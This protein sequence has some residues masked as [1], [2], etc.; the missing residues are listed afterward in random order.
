M[1]DDNRERS[2]HLTTEQL[3][4][5]IEGRLSSDDLKQVEVHL[6]SDC[7]SCQDELASLTRILN[8]MTRNI[9]VDAP[10]QQQ[11][12]ARKI[13]RDHYSVERETF[14]IGQWLQTLFS[15]SRPLVYAA[16]GILLVVV[17]AGLLLRPPSSAPE[18][19]SADVV[20]YQGTVE[21]QSS[22]DDEWQS[23]ESA[24]EVT[25]GD[26][27]RTGD[28]SSIVL[29]FPDESKLLMAPQTKI[30]IVEMS[31]DVESGAQVV[32]LQQ[33]IG[34]TQNFVEP[35]PSEDSRYEIQTPA[36]TVTVWGTAFTVEVEADG[37]THVAVSEGRVQVEAQGEAI[38]LDAGEGTTVKS[39][40]APSSVEPVPTDELAPNEVATLVSTAI[41]TA[42]PLNAP[43]ELPGEQ[44]GPTEPTATATLRPTETAGSSPA[45]TPT[46][47]ASRP[48]TS[49][50]TPTSTSAPSATPT[51]EVVA[52]NTPK[53]EPTSTP[54]P[55]PVPTDTPQP[56]PTNTPV[57]P[58]PTATSPPPPTPTDVPPPTPTATETPRVPPGQTKTPQPPGQTQTAAPS[59][60]HQTN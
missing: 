59:E 16:I 29:S 12:S 28:D 44:N 46:P 34:R 18:S 39:G 33:Q 2:K 60:H 36:V 31:S 24:E 47:T 11:A 9:W 58:T 57:G 6:A 40:D 53:P 5:Y 22:D 7:S 30:K 52:T 1:M 20:A 13:Y 45:P 37:T 23:V 41:A 56:T 35:Q 54:T 10:A 42:A 38:F 3:L 48:Q 15:P 32:V 4:D 8:L 55:I 51:R 17:V 50:P 26:D 25:A 43:T 19:G 27:V 49:S 14:S 21:V